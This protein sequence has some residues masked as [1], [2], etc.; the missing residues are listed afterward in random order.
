[1]QG[2]RFL[3]TIQLSNLLSFGKEGVRLDLE[4]LNVLI[5]PNGAGKS[6]L[7][8][9]LTLL[10]AAPRDLSACI[11]EGGG[12][13]EW[14]WK[15]VERTSVAEI[16]AILSQPELFYR[17]VFTSVASRFQVQSE[18]LNEGTSPVQGPL[19]LLGAGKA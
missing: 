15:G 3:S 14:I 10:A 16:I 8:E 5:G 9:A 2:A 1:M 7:V 4:P 12:A 19:Y 18:N 11:R 13:A 6:N 17:L